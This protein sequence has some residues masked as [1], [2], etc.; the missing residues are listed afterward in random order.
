MVAYSRFYCTFLFAGTNNSDG[1]GTLFSSGLYEHY[2]E[3]YEIILTPEEIFIKYLY[4][5]VF[6]FFLLLGTVGNILSLLLMRKYSRNVWSTCLY[7]VIIL[8][9]DLIKLYVECGNDWYTK[10][11]DQNLSVE[12][13]LISNAVCKVYMFLYNLIIHSSSWLTVAVGIEMMI[14]M[15]FPLRIYR[16]CTR[17]RAMSVILLIL[18]LLISL[19]LHF[20]WTFGLTIPGDDVSIQIVL[21]T[22]INELSNDFRDYIWPLIDFFIADLIPLLILA[23]CVI[24]TVPSTINKRNKSEELDNLLQKYFMDIKALHEIK[25]SIFV[26][27]IGNVLALLCRVSETGLRNLI[28]NGLLDMEI[29][30]WFLA[31]GIL[32]T[33][34]YCFLSCKIILFLIFSSRFRQDSKE[35]IRFCF[36]PICGKNV[37]RRSRKCVLITQQTAHTSWNEDVEEKHLR[38]VDVH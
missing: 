37:C 2:Y 15:R 27:T 11:Q 36:S 26:I 19:N 21:C 12:I 8:G 38:L 6:P 28:N 34:S 10:I 35:L 29:Q 1:Y 31:Q 32:R 23:V 25:T 17:D 7:M 20:F 16:M 30:D 3:D 24:I 13:L 14:S 33:L 22:Y 9:M 18:V 5:T 4:I